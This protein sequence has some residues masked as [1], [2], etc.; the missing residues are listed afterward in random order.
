MANNASSTTIIFVPGGWHTPECFDDVAERLSETGY[1]TNYVRLASVGPKEHVKSIQPDVDVIRSHVEG[2]VNQGQK[3]VMVM[4]SYASVPTCD[5]VYGLEY[6]TRQAEGKEGGVTHLFFMSAFIIGG[7]MSLL[8]AF[9]G[10]D[11][12]WWDISEDKLEVQPIK[13]EEIFYN[14]MPEDLQKSAIASLKSFSYQV[15]HSKMQH[16]SWQVIPSTFLYC[17][18][19]KAIPPF[20]QEMMVKEVAK[21]YEIRTETVDA[22]HSPFVMKAEETA[23]AIRRAAE[24]PV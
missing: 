17:S 4:H 15:F 20:I 3:V 7:G 2:A 11:L 14:D 8:D 6:K 1:Q 22:G 9:G 10:N 19:D 5:A 16:A 18:Q 23:A 24:L 13:P 21:G 12:P